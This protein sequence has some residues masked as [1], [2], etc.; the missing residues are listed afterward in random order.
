LLHR[1]PKTL[2]REWTDITLAAEE[3]FGPSFFKKS[4]AAYFV[5]NV[6]HAAAGTR[7]AP[8]WWL[9]MHKHEARCSAVA[10]YRHALPGKRHQTETAREI[11]NRIVKEHQLPIDLTGVDAPP[12]KKAP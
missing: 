8:D 6:K 4:P 7:T 5:D 3:R 9:E 2:L 11:V 12:P 1:Y 10:K